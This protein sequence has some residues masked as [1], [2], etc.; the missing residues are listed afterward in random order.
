MRYYKFAALFPLAFIAAVGIISGITHD[1]LGIGK[2][3]KSEWFTT[4][5]WWESVVLAILFSGFICIFSLPMF[6][7]N[8]ER[9]K[10]NTFLKI[11]VWFAAP[12]SLIAYV[13]TKHIHFLINY[14]DGSYGESIF[15]FTILLPHLI[16]LIVS[17]TKFER[18]LQME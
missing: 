6:L 7:A 17:F 4:D 8:Y 15:L 1:I 11:V 10:T 14:G 16:G 18:K 2:D 9:V 5:G 3:Y 13:L 12:C